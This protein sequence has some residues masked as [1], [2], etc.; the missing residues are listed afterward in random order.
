MSLRAFRLIG[1]GLV[2]GA[3]ALLV[4]PEPLYAG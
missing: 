4:P 3:T 1:F 2:F